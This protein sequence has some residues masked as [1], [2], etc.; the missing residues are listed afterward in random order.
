MGD[1]IGG[2]DHL[3]EIV[4]Y[5]EQLAR[6]EPGSDFRLQIGGDGLQTQTLGKRHCHDLG[7]FHRGQRDKTDTISKT[8]GLAGGCFDGQAR[9]ADAAGAEQGQQSTVRVG[10]QR[11]DLRQ[12]CA[13][14]DEGRGL[15][16][17]IVQR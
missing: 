7:G 2:H 13:A 9:L 14:P 1:C 4:E 12:V 15:S 8:A 10:E 16:R 6:A 5:Q 11:L 17:E 3:L